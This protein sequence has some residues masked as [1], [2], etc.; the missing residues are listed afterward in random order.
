MET[1][2]LTFTL[3]GIAYRIDPHIWTAHPDRV[4][5]VTVERIVEAIGHPDFQ[6]TESEY[7]TY[8]WKWYHE[9]G[10]EGN[11]IKVIVNSRRETRLVST[12]YPDENFRRRQQRDG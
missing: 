5:L 7:L 11:Y 10:T 8:F 2:A 9:V 1:D 4:G 3:N 6:E 12:A